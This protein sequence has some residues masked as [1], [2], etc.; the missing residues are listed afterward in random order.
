MCWRSSTAALT[1]AAACIAV[2][3]KSSTDGVRSDEV[4]TRAPV[5][6]MPLCSQPPCTR[7]PP[8]PPPPNDGCATSKD[9]SLSTCRLP[10]PGTHCVSAGEGS[11]Y[12]CTRDDIGLSWMPTRAPGQRCTIVSRPAATNYLCWNPGAAADLS[13]AAG[14]TGDNGTGPCVTWQTPSDGALCEIDPP[15]TCDQNSGASNDGLDLSMFVVSLHHVPPDDKAT[16]NPDQANQAA[17]EFARYSFPFISSVS[18]VIVIPAAPYWAKPGELTMGGGQS[19]GRWFYSR[20]MK[21]PTFS[22][23]QY[24]E[25]YDATG[26]LTGG[27]AS[28]NRL[29][30]LGIIVGPGWSGSFQ[31]RR[32][33]LT[34]L[35]EGYDFGDATLTTGSM[36]VHVLIVQTDGNRPEEQLRYLMNTYKPDR[37]GSEPNIIAGDFNIYEG[38]SSVAVRPDLLSQNWLTCGHACSNR[39][40]LVAFRDPTP[41]KLHVVQMAG[42]TQLSY[43]G[44]AFSP[45][46]IAQ[47]ILTTELPL[48]PLTHI[49]T[50]AFF[51]IRPQR[52]ATKVACAPPL[53]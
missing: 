29:N 8:P 52:V 13:F 21:S 46:A 3:C 32:F 15:R 33:P 35:G 53:P 17:D 37:P 31:R 44:A 5:E 38:D 19:S 22:G 39:P 50:S 42:P 43:V 18:Y 11:G 28:H 48:P 26:Y 49:P 40:E 6:P 12:V 9:G 24:F 1:V 7:T 10:K 25:G 20:L 2:G 36:S 27:V 16:P 30:N 14:R 23:A 51:K 41:S 47:G 34:D 4:K 45:D